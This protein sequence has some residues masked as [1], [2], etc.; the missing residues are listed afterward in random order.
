MPALL[1]ALRLITLVGWLYWLIFY[2]RGGLRLIEDIM[3]HFADNRA[4][5]FADH[6][7]HLLSLMIITPV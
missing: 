2:W 5:H 7:H 1:L 4:R 3:I 6:P